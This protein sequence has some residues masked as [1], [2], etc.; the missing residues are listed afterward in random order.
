MIKSWDVTIGTVLSV[1]VEKHVNVDSS[2]VTKQ[3]VSLMKQE[4]CSRAF[5]SDTRKTKTR[6]IELDS[7][8]VI[9]YQALMSEAPVGDSPSKR[10]GQMK[11]QKA[12]LG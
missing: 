10:S 1:T 3:V 7:P 9:N 5:V 12:S 4:M 2:D 8:E 6:L 11:A